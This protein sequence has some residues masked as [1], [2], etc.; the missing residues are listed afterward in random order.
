M[1]PLNLEKLARKLRTVPAT[2][3]NLERIFKL[4]TSLDG[5]PVMEE[6][7]YGI[8]WEDHACAIPNPRPSR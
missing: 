6:I 5:K 4:K 1:I 7:R 8:V 2:K 3:K